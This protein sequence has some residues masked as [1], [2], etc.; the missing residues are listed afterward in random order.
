MKTD[1]SVKIFATLEELYTVSDVAQALKVQPKTVY[2]MI[3]DGVLKAGKVGRV[4]RIR[5]SDVQAAIGRAR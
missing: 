3:S 1:K 4:W 2:K 5:A